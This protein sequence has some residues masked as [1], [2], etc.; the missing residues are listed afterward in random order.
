MNRADRRA[1]GEKNSIAAANRRAAPIKQARED[2]RPL[3]YDVNTHNGVQCLLCAQ[4]GNVSMYKLR[5]AM[6]CDPANSPLEDGAV[7]TICIHH[8]P[9]DAVIY[10]PED[11]TCRNKSGDHTWKE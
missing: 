3:Y 8:L 11:Q 10:N 5:E 6:M 2:G 4:N 9:E 1:R 7:Y